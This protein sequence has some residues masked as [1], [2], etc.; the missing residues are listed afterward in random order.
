MAA[1]G[2]RLTT[3]IDA[4]HAEVIL[5]LKAWVAGHWNYAHQSLHLEYDTYYACGS[6][7]QPP[8]HSEMVE[9]EKSL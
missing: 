9:R 2:K 1:K 7:A 3:S 8:M 5:E 6:S 4:I